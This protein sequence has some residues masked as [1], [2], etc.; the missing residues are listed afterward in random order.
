[1]QY[2][3]ICLIAKD[4]DYYLKEWI[5][6]HLQIGFD[7][8]I[9]YDNGSVV[10]VRDTLADFIDIGRVVVHDAPG[11][12]RQ[13]AC[14]TDCITQYRHT[15]KWIAFIDS[16]EFIFPKA[17]RNI[18]V[19]LAEYEN[20]GGVVAHWVMFG[21]SGLSRRKGGSQIFNFVMRSGKESSIFKSIV[22]PATVKQ[23]GV[24]GAEFIESY[25]AVSS[26][27]FP[28]HT[29]G[30]STPFINDKIQINHYYYRTWEDYECK[31]ARWIALKKMDKAITPEEEKAEF[32]VPSMELIRFYAPLQG[33][34]IAEHAPGPRPMT[35]QE[36]VDKAMDF[37]DGRTSFTA[38]KALALELFLCE[39]SLAFPQEPLIWYFRAVASRLCG[40]CPRAFIC[41][42]EAAKLSGNSMIY[43]ELSRIYLAMEQPE[44]AKRAEQHAAY[45]KQIEDRT[46]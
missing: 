15:F 10:P 7:A 29:D 45:K 6:Y 4:E 18:K 35:V 12:F 14:Y 23:Y 34:P 42:R 32:F 3:A 43:H 24:H 19:F 30:Y 46:C 25:Y 27:H 22:R 40:D 44:Q 41:I 17:T 13:S 11:E 16:D 37:L 2:C 8:I 20:Y 5:E 39:A 1:M 31:A 36:I 26:D 21:T 33:R 9:V 38:Q 28:V